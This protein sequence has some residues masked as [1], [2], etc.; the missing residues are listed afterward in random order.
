MAA[1]F[2][3]IRLCCNKIDACFS[4]TEKG[5]FTFGVEDNIFAGNC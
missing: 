1:K 4:Y 3:V 2:V 5:E